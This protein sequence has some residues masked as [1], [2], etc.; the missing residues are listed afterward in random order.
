MKYVKKGE[1]GIL[2]S[3]IYP[4]PL[5]PVVTTEVTISRSETIS[6]MKEHGKL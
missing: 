1:R 4:K 6:K 2:L 5:P 3:I